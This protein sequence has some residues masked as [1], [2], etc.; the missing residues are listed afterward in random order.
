M[1]I[2]IYFFLLETSIRLK[3]KIQHLCVFLVPSQAQQ[4]NKQQQQQQNTWTQLYSLFVK[5]GQ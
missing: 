5:V 4:T 1:W 2:C 3:G